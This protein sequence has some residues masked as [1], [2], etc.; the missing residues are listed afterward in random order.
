M[1]KATRALLSP[2]TS[3]VFYILIGTR[4]LNPGAQGQ[5]EQTLVVASPCMDAPKHSL[6]TT[7]GDD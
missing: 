4:I 7:G 6:G 2:E 1:T 3:G 5:D